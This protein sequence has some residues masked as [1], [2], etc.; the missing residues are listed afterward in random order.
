MKYKLAI[1]D[2]DGTVFDTYT[3]VS[4]SLVYAFDRLGIAP[5]PESVLRTFLG[6]SL[7]ESFTGTMGL[8]DATA[9]RAIDLF[10]SVYTVE[11]YKHATFYDGIPALF[12]RLSAAGVTLAVASSKA[13]PVV[14]ELLRYQGILDRFAVV[15]APELGEKGSDKRDLVARA[16]QSAS[17]G[18]PAVMIGDRK[19]DLLA[20]AQVGID[21]IGVTYGFGTREEL[22]ACPHVYLADSAKDVGDYILQK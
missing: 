7:Y 5:P 11:N 22:D 6:P 4:E 21:G 3:G 14:I 19:F 18:Q 2:V 12:D 1:F 9:R 8:D 15:C 17:S 16:V 20:A 13:R 10:R